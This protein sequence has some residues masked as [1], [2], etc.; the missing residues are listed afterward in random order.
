M[1]T[2]FNEREA[3]HEVIRSLLKALN[4]RHGMLRIFQDARG[5]I[6]KAHEFEELGR[7]EAVKLLS[8]LEDGLA[9]VKSYLERLDAQANPPADQLANGDDNGQSDQGAPTDG[10]QPSSDAQPTLSSDNGTPAAPATN[11][12]DASVPPVD[13]SAPAQ[14][15][16]DQSQVTLPADPNPAQP[17]QPAVPQIQ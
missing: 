12:A 8:D 5:L 15:A 10:S 14:P 11:P 9:I 16:E 1:N 13:G 6:Y 17:E 2:L 3:D 7:E 4:R